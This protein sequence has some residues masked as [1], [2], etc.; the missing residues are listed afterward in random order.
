MATGMRS[1]ALTALLLGVAVAC[2]QLVGIGD[3][4]PTG[5]SPADAAPACG[6]TYAGASCEACVEAHCCQQASECEGDP[7]CKSTAACLASCAGDPRCTAACTYGTVPPL[8]SSAASTVALGT[9]LAQNCERECSLGCGPAVYVQPDAAASCHDCFSMNA[10]STSHDCSVSAAC[11]AENL[12]TLTCEGR[13]D[14]LTGCGALDD[15]GSSLFRA[16]ALVVQ[17]TCAEACAI[18]SNWG[19]LDHFV[20]APASNGQPTEVDVNTVLLGGNTAWPGIQVAVCSTGTCGARSGP[21]PSDGG[22]VTVAVP[23]TS[24]NHGGYVGPTGY[25]ELSSIPDAGSSAIVLEDLYWGF[26]LSQPRMDLA[27]YVVT[28][29]L[30]SEIYAEAEQGTAPMP[31]RGTLLIGAL[32]CANTRAKGLSFDAGLPTQTFYFS[33]GGTIDRSA[34]QTGRLG[35]AVI[36]N[37]EPG[38]VTVT[39]TAT[40]LGRA[41]SHGNATVQAGAVTLLYMSPSP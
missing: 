35:A 17:G 13:L 39:A 7:S 8:P 37:V 33:D 22:P 31:G 40:Q 27:A 30:L 1:V 32:N 12:C 29:F 11:T 6:I 34:T 25:L 15:A 38:S 2:R 20:S 36:T 16:V 9:C 14:C 3:S 28:P 5:S 21:T 4:P 24:A 19:C 23:T 41:V 18:N 26:P 10:C